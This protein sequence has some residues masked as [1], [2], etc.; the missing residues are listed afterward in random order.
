MTLPTISMSSAKASSSSAPMPATFSRS[1]SDDWRI[2]A[3]RTGP[4][5]L[6]PVPNAYGVCAVSP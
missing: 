2:A 1:K 6:P 4:L 3:P 5:R